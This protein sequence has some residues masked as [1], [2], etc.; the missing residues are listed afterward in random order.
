MENTKIVRL[1]SR[2][3]KNEIKEFKSFISS[4]YFSRGRNLVPYYTILCKYYPEFDSENF[5]TEKIF[6]ALYPEKKFDLK[7]A[8]HTLQVLSSELTVLCEKFLVYNSFEKGNRKY[9]YNFFLA[10]SYRDIGFIGQALKLLQ[11]NSELIHKDDSGS[12][13]FMRIL[14]TNMSLSGVYFTQNKFSES[15]KFSENNLLYIYA[16]F[17]DLINKFTNEHFVNLRNYN[18]SFRGFEIIKE[19]I[20]SFNPER[21][22][23]EIG[24]DK[25]EAKNLLYINY[26]LIRSRLG[27]SEKQDLMSAM[28]IYLKIFQKLSRHNQWFLFALLFNRLYGRIRYDKFYSGKANELID[29]VWEKGILS[30]HEKIPLHAGSYHSA[31]MVKAFSGD[32]ENL[33]IFIRK[34]SEKVMPELAEDIQ[35]Y[36]NA[37]LNFK[38]ESYE[39]CLFMVSKKDKLTSPAL[40]ICKHKLKIICLFELR[41]TEEA[42]LAIDSFEHYLRNNKNVYEILKTENLQF[43]SSIRKLLKNF[44]EKRFDA[45]FEFLKLSETEKNSIFG[46]WLEKKWQASGLPGC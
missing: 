46:L 10:E 3:N 32:T 26:F 31:L 24:D 5:T 38:N 44:Y 29:F 19:F 21:F 37:I 25:F 27:G 43:T 34:Y 8:A 14:E 20:V 22:E 4:P 35:E 23:K 30:T 17:F 28:E 7:A 12:D 2:F 16:H 40:K 13:I 15:F 42:L 9:N 33:K 36:S 6:K 45:E 11:K 39:K 41:H 18:L 1:L